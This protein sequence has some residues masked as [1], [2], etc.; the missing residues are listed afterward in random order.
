MQG[1]INSLAL[2]DGQQWPSGRFGSFDDMGMMMTN[3]DYSNVSFDE[4]VSSPTFNRQMP[5]NC[6]GN[7]YASVESESDDHHLDLSL[8]FDF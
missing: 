6:V 8:A 3:S 4:P 7:D 5:I 1:V 2:Q